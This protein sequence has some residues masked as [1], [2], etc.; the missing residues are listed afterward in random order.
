MDLDTK[1]TIE[2]LGE[3]NFETWSFY[4]EAALDAKDLWKV[5]VPGTEPDDAA[6]R[7]A[8]NFIRLHIKP[9]Y[10]S[11]LRGC[12]TAKEAWEKLKSMHASKNKAR[13]LNAMRELNNLRMNTGESIT[14]YFARA[15][16]L[17]DMVI[18]AGSSVTDEDFCLRVLNGLP[19]EYDM[20]ATA[21]TVSAATLDLTVMR[22]TLLQMEQKLMARSPNGNPE[23]E[24][25]LFVKGKFRPNKGGGNVNKG[26]GNANKGNANKNPHHDRTCFNC[27]KMGHI[28]A[29][30]RK[31]PRNNNNKFVKNAQSNFASDDDFALAATNGMRMRSWQWMLDSGASSHMTP[32]LKLLQWD[33]RPA[34]PDHFVTF[35]N[36]AKAK[37]EAIG[38]TV[39]YTPEKP[40][41][42]WLKDVLY[43]PSLAL[44]LMSV[45]RAAVNGCTITYDGTDCELKRGDK[46][47]AK[48][49]C[50]P[51]GDVYV[52]GIRSMRLDDH[53]LLAKAAESASLLHRRYGHLG[54]D[55]MAKLVKHSMVNGLDVDPSTFDEA[56]KEPCEPC[57][58]GKAHR[59]PFPESD[60][61]AKQ[62]LDVLHMDVCG[63]MPV[64]SIGGARYLATITDGYSRYAVVKPIR[65]KSDVVD[66]VQ[67][68]IPVL[69]TQTGRSVRKVRTDNGKEYVNNVLTT[70][71]NA[72]GIIHETTVPYTPEQNGVAER[73][74]RTIMEKVRA[75]L[76][77]GDLPQEL[78]AEAAVTANYLRNRSPTSGHNKTPLEV[79]SGVKPDV[80]HLRV[81]GSVA[82]AHLPKERRTKLDDKAVRGLM[83]GYATATKGYRILMPDNSVIT[84]RDVVFNEG[85]GDDSGL[86][87]VLHD[88]DEDD[89]VIGDAADNNNAANTNA[90]NPGVPRASKRTSVK[91]GEWWKVKPTTD[92]ANAAICAI[93]E[94]K[95][96][97]EALAGDNKA[98]WQTAMD[99]EYQSLIVNNT[100]EVVPCPKDVKPIPTKWVY[101]VK[102]TADGNFERFKARL[103][104]KGFKQ[105]EGIDF[106]EVYA[107][108]SKQATV[109]ALLA[110]AAAQDLEL[111]QLDVKT[112][113]LNGELEEEVY[114]LQPPGYTTHDSTHACLLKRALYGLRQAPRTWHMRLKKDL[115][116]A[117]FVE[118]Q[119]DPGLFIA[120]HE[121]GIIYLLVY[122]DDILLV[123]NKEALQDA[124]SLIMGLYDM[125]DLGETSSFLG[126]SILRDR[127]NKT[128]KVTQAGMTTDLLSTFN[129]L[130]AKPKA[131]PMSVSVKLT[132]EG[133]PLN[134][135]THPY[136]KLIGKLLWLSIS[137][138]PDIAYAVGALSKFLSAP[139]TDHWRAAKDVL[140]YLAGT[141]EYGIVFGGSDLSLHGYCDADYAGD[142]DSRKS[143]SGYAFL[144]NGGVLSWSSKRQ[145]TVAVSTT[146]AEYIAAAHA[147]KEANWLRTLLCE[148]GLPHLGIPLNVDNQSAIALLKNP[149]ISPRSKHIDIVYHFAREH[150]SRKEIVISYISTDKMIADIFTKAVP[151]AKH[152]FCTKGM[153]VHV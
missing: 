1:L 93:T 24:T 112:A 100:W 107:P 122:V 79:F 61:T 134:T 22:S 42:F 78:W 88:K 132:K 47:L 91:P 31:P 121:K 109:R 19:A 114:V 108:V 151:E 68:T 111:H 37:V 18:G 105:I 35:G 28:A 66:F 116:A 40:G 77:D 32:H 67:R 106:D 101:K 97:E 58:M 98:E 119:A 15:N 94:P 69:E 133:E 142:I 125:R 11:D 124:K 95:S 104:A 84:S 23:A 53:A 118:S 2:K 110:V 72:K 86:P 36:S 63:P 65:Y 70:Y 135:D 46:L 3:D 62:L 12:T 34:A 123:T 117:G 52:L 27:G 127:V 89:G 4:V 103:V 152:V 80:S 48:A 57:V 44:N 45:S 150:V 153:G 139:T 13:R 25:A 39:V 16:G 29:D 90:D 73:L 10:I 149:I 120:H 83:V 140:R 51:E 74:N 6:N 115:E 75:M 102:R 113:F 7:K 96:R 147:I 8:L 126:M 92:T 138:R 64:D 26:G 136:R 49:Q 33:L 9:M 56:N 143:T 55:N 54:H 43:V 30:C 131:V 17:K 21:L 146:E 20:V 41:G 99:D 129:M 81:F 85:K 128:I 148:L 14:K 60:N 50:N 5:I 82:Y 59:L 87:H 137:T 38:T 141:V 130:D 71:F 144:L 76:H 145:A